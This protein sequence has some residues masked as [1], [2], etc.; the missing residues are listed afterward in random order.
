MNDKQKMMIEKFQCVGCTC[1]GDV[2]CDHFKF[3][4]EKPVGCWCEGHSAGTFLGGVGKIALGLPTGFDRVGT[5]K[6]GFEERDERSTNIRLY[7]DPSIPSYDNLNVPVWAMEEE[8][9][10][11][12]RVMSPRINYN[13]VDIITDGKFDKICP[14]AIDVAKFKDEID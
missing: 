12:I 5:I 7:E 14:N 9:Y 13:F 1:G 4:E 2:S 3:V 6:T 10:L 11:F 8:G